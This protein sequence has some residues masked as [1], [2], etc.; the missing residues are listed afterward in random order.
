M[1][2]SNN[3]KDWITYRNIN[4]MQLFNTFSS[5]DT[6]M[7]HSYMALAIQP[8]NSIWLRKMHMYMDALHHS[9]CYGMCTF[10]DGRQNKEFAIELLAT[11]MLHRLI[12]DIV[13]F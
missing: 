8:Y 10:T 4:Q 12:L 3:F 2:K 7:V 9:P 5:N 6:T 1:L 11:Y 13:Q